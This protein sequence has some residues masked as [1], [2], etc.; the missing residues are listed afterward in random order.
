MHKTHPFR[1]IRWVVSFITLATLFF[2]LPA[3]CNHS[4][5]LGD[6]DRDGIVNSADIDDDNDGLIEIH[7]LDMFDNI[8]NNL[9]GT[10]YNDDTTG[11]PRS[12]TANCPTDP[13]DDGFF[14]CGYEL[15]TNLDFESY[16]S[17]ASGFTSWMNKTWRPAN[18]LTPNRYSTVVAPDSAVNAGFSGIGAATGNTGGFAAI[19]EGNGHTITNFY[20]RNTTCFGTVTFSCNIG[21]FRLTGSAAQIRNLE[22]T[23]A[24]VYGAGGV[25][26]IGGLVG[27]NEGTITESSASGSVD[28]RGG[29]DDRVG[30]LVGQ[31]N[32]STITASYATVDADGGDGDE[33]YV[34]GLVGQNT[35]TIT[36]SYATGNADG[37]DGGTD[38]VGGLVGQISTASSNIIASYATGNADGGDGEADRVGGL[39]GEIGNLSAVTASY[40]IGDAD[41]G[42]GG[43]SRV[44]GLAGWS[45]G[46]IITASYATGSVNGGDGT[47][48]T[49]GGLLGA[50]QLDV[51]IQ[52]YSFGTPMGENIGSAGTGLPDLADLALITSATQLGDVRTL[53]TANAGASDWWNSASST[54][55]GA[56]NFGTPTENP[57]LVYSDYD[58]T[59]GTDYASCSDDNGG[60]PDTI[61]G[62][63]IPLVCGTTL[64]GDYR[65]PVTP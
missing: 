35:G 23:N 58:G 62:T 30:G 3:S 2:I 12:A 64:V 33:D 6:P 50:T 13:D 41:G 31:N 17:Y 18:E 60:F 14:L 11:A 63:N 36:A 65:P 29:D 57:A 25:D 9:A 37:G 44:G 22:V 39:V 53:I 32:T 4:P 24:N 42:D 51:I 59:A 45:I 28:A 16:S 55:A 5:T 46:A 49:A 27:H 61:P 26:K 52:S 47:N 56:W 19:F 10:S 8:R 40:A 48:D 34:G 20:S 15:V 54:D 7:N 1:T 43:D 21:L 38:R